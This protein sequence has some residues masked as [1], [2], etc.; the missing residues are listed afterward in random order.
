MK[1]K[2]RESMKCLLASKL[3]DIISHLCKWQNILLSSKD[4]CGLPYRSLSAEVIDTGEDSVNEK[5]K[6]IITIDQ[7]VNNESV[8]STYIDAV[9]W[10]LENRKKNDIRNIAITGSYGSGKSSILKTF[11]KHNRDKKIKCLNISLASFGEVK[12]GEDLSRLLE[13]SILQQIIH[14]EKDSVIPDSKIKKIRHL[15]A[16]ELSLCVIGI[17]L[18]SISLVNIYNHI[19]L[20]REILKMDPS[21]TV[22]SLF[23]YISLLFIV[24]GVC[25]VLWKFVRI[26]SSARI[27][28]LSFHNTEIELDD[29]IS[30]SILNHHIDEILY[31]FEVSGNNVVIIED[32]D[33]FK[34][35]EIFTK[36]REINL[37][38]NNSNKVD[39]D[40]VFIYAIKDEMFVNKERTKFFDFIIPVISV[41][42][43]S[44]SCGKFLDRLIEY[45][46]EISDKPLVGISESLVEDISL[47]VDDMRLLHN[48]VN[49]F[50][51][52][53]KKI[54][55]NKDKNRLLSMVVYKNICPSDFARL[56]YNEGVL[57]DCIRSKSKY[58]ISEYKRIDSLINTIKV[59]IKELEKIKI[60]DLKELRSLYLFKCYRYINDYKPLY[61]NND[62]VEIEHLVEEDKFAYMLEDKVM[63]K[64]KYYNELAVLP[65]T[66]KQIQDEVD[67]EK[68]YEKRKNE[69][70][71][72]NDGKVN[73][74][75][76]GIEKLKE[77]QSLLRHK[78]VGEL[79]SAHKL[80]EYSSS[81]IDKQQIALLSLFIRSEYIDE[82]YLDYISY[83][84]EG[85]I[86]RTDQQF[87]LNVKNQN[88]SEYDYSLVRKEKLVSKIQISD[89]KKEYI[90]NYDLVDFIIGKDVYKE[91]NDFLFD[92]L[93][94]ESKTVISYIDG[95]I[96]NGIKIALFIE[97][98]SARWPN[99]W[100]YIC[101][102]T[103]YTEE[104]KYKYLQLILDHAEIENIK[105]L[106]DSSLL[107]K[108][109]SRNKEFLKIIS[110]EEKLQSV[111]KAL[112]I[113]FVDLDIE[114]ASKSMLDFVYEGDF[115]E[116]NIIVF[117]KMLRYKDAFDKVA[118]ETKNYTLIRNS[119]CDGLLAY[120]NIN[121]NVY[122]SEVYL[123]IETNRKEEK[124]CL[125]ELLN[126]DDLLDEKKKEIILSVE[127]K[128]P[129]LYDIN[130]FDLLDSIMEALKVEANWDSIIYYYMNNN[131]KFS[132][133][134]I[135]FVNCLENAENLSD[136]EIEKI[137]E[138]KQFIRALI[139]E[140]KISD[141]C[142]KLVL[143][144]VP[145]SYDS[146]DLSNLSEAKVGLLICNKLLVLNA[147]NYNMLKN[148]FE[149]LHIKFVESNIE[150]FMED[151]S[152]CPI[153]QD[154]M[155]YLLESEDILYNNKNAIINKFDID[156][157]VCNVKSLKII[158][159]LII[160]EDSF[161]V[162]KDI[163]EQILIIDSL[164][165]DD[166]YDLLLMSISDMFD[167]L[168][169]ENLSENKVRLLFYNNVLNF[170]ESNYGLLREKFNGLHIGFIECNIEE[171]LSDVL[172]YEIETD[173]VRL[174]LESA[175]L[176]LDDKKMLISEID[177]EYYISNNKENLDIASNLLLKDPSFSDSYKIINNLLLDEKK[178]EMERIRMF[179]LKQG[180]S[181]ELDIKNFLKSLG[182]PF[183]EFTIIRKT[184]SIENNESN[185]EFVNELYN[186]GYVRTYESVEDKI[187]VK[188]CWK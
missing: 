136:S 137:E 178:N 135:N 162:S 71:G 97:K 30:K 75:K 170:N 140:E 31:F 34:Q 139:L 89:F 15:K 123:K 81:S 14:H 51:I 2:N 79:F 4:L 93:V 179:N 57:Y 23:H 80:D 82:N 154:D 148:N 43:S 28:K 147:D 16:R 127:T 187:I 146:I 111:I 169:F 92:L 156:L 77:E 86:S 112:E 67:V 66:F 26:F 44:N 20:F 68:S 152:L 46:F 39:D 117:E 99:F 110:N 9:Q 61:I 78:K 94:N 5:A 121:I 91:H 53:N 143:N 55:D 173:D 142:Y 104:R 180:F 58:V 183:S 100:N 49:E 88:I 32:I 176:T 113:K 168:S 11:L 33:R 70:V 181:G 48:I 37:L 138:Y 52:Y 102:Q 160:S 85:T 122:I 73:V 65:I 47:F 76:K 115:Y 165:D 84:H 174:L 63:Y 69:V 172:S 56:A 182:E 144:S 36:L 24:F 90:L 157:V 54:G 50:Y 95:Y 164:L 3:G 132:S 185:L 119:G 103:D 149:V 186:R 129:G 96:D 128:I 8:D 158:A 126:N 105:V 40:I 29:K 118:F 59:E 107:K 27:S 150:T 35:T 188:S 161:K 114:D 19:W 171:F 153:D 22:E 108:Q 18:C 163:V 166:D 42:N 21:K 167:S 184:I 145:Y 131:D 101:S 116:F 155:L 87:L 10:A 125:V 41:I 83:F 17:L 45:G 1:S 177:E 7:E 98:L 134:L 124:G 72:W 64:T 175:E 25:M 62:I 12:E 159:E 60:I 130:D 109:I 13:L 6:E 141:E 38:I 106:A 133:A 120:V 151:L 74:L